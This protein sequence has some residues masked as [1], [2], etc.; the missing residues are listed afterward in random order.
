MP[1]VTNQMPRLLSKHKTDDKITDIVII[2]L[3]VGIGIF[4]TQ[5]HKQRPV[6]RATAQK[7]AVGNNQKEIKKNDTES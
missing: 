2:A 3:I 1:L 6:M 4:A 7:Q 5:R